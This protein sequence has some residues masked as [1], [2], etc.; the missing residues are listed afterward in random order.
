M[1]NYRQVRQLLLQTFDVPVR[2]RSWDTQQI[3]PMGIP[4]ENLS[5]TRVELKEVF[6]E[7]KCGNIYNSQSTDTEGAMESVCINGVSVLSGSCY[8]SNKYTFYLVKILQ[9]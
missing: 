8:L 9:K 6:N 5:F 2:A 1:L 4:K 3:M 7:E